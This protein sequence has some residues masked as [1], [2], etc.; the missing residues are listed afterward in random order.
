MKHNFM[1]SILNHVTGNFVTGG[2][3]RAVKALAEENDKTYTAQRNLI[4]ELSNEIN[5]TKAKLDEANAIL[6][7]LWEHGAFAICSEIGADDLWDCYQDAKGRR[8][9]KS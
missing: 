6:D 4:Y 7:G 5:A 9:E 1:Y 3:Y 2:H 8:N